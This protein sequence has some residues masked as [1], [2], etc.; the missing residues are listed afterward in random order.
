MLTKTPTCHAI[1][2][3]L[4]CKLPMHFSSISS[5]DLYIL[6]VITSQ[7]DA[8]HDHQLLV[9]ELKEW[10]KHLADYFDTCIHPLQMFTIV[11]NSAKSTDSDPWIDNLINILHSF[12]QVLTFP[13]RKR[14]KQKSHG[15]EFKNHALTERIEH[16]SIIGKK[17]DACR[18]G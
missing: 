5:D 13:F 11:I 12:C 17:C 9:L 18:S 7:T 3:I 8:T 2:L 15:W 4:P 16:Y 10:P 1:S 14:W 6:V